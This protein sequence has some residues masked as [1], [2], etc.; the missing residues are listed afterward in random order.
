MK[1]ILAFFA[2]C[3]LLSPQSF[4]NADSTT[5]E[6]NK[7]IETKKNILSVEDERLFNAGRLDETIV[8]PVYTTVEQVIFTEQVNQVKSED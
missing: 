5:V 6:T 1:T 7:K 8:K 3:T 4:A 2:F